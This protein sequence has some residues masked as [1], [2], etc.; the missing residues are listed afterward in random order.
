MQLLVAKA[1]P[2]LVDVDGQSPLDLAIM[3]KETAIANHIRFWMSKVKVL[4][5]LLTFQKGIR[6]HIPLIYNTVLSHKNET[7]YWTRDVVC[8]LPLPMRATCIY[9]MLHKHLHHYDKES[10]RFSS[11]CEGILS[12][13]SML[14]RCNF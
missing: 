7:I 1:N 4:V 12:H 6:A 9:A 13:I 5:S 3:W 14:M 10:K 8:S 11:D 2:L